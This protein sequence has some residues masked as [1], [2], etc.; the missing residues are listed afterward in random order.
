[1][2]AFEDIRSCTLKA[3]ELLRDLR[4]DDLER[5]LVLREEV[6]QQ[7]R[8]LTVDQLEA[9][10]EMDRQ[11]VAGAGALLA[12]L[13]DELRGLRETRELLSVYRF[14]LGDASAFVDRT[15]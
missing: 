7:M 10:A 13:K 12:Q 5:L 15:V 8:G 1:M 11:F 6:L 9:I 2:S 3:L 4:L 14:T